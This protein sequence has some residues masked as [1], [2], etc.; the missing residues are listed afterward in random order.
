MYMPGISVCVQ[1]TANGLR[2]A[3]MAGKLVVKLRYSSLPV[4]TIHNRYRCPFQFHS[5]NLAWPL[6]VLSAVMHAYFSSFVVSFDAI[7]R[8]N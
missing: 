3:Y 5:D 1:M 7:F 6:T 8:H 4:G 2:D